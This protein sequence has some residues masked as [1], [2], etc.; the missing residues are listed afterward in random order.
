[1]KIVKK[2]II[3]ELPETLEDGSSKIMCDKPYRI[4]RIEEDGEI[5]WFGYNTNW[6]KT[7]GKWYKLETME[8]VECETPEYE[9]MYLELI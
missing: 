6:K 8:F 1:M 2:S 7:D 3:L 4:E 5:I 9:K